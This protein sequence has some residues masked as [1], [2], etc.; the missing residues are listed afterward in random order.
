MA[1][2][3]GVMACG[4]LFIPDRSGNVPG[5]LVQVSPSLCGFTFGVARMG[6]HL[7]DTEM[8]NIQKWKASSWTAV[9]IH[10]RLSTDRCMF[11][12][13]RLPVMSFA[14]GVLVYIL[15][16]H[17]CVVCFQL[18]PENAVTFCSG[19]VRVCIWHL[20]FGQLGFDL[21]MLMTRFHGNFGFYRFLFHA[22][23]LR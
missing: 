3:F 18:A 19:A 1:V 8:D 11:W 17:I 23:V 21:I 12:Q 10:Q 16:G 6:K 2:R 9:Q 14:T 4:R 22:V 7:S 5:Q 15:G 20:F 13:C